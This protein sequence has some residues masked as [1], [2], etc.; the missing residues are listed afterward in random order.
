MQIIVGKVFLS[1]PQFHFFCFTFAWATH[2]VNYV[3]LFA[4]SGPLAIR[5]VTFW[6]SV[7]VPTYWTFFYFCMRHI[8]KKIISINNIHTPPTEHL[9]QLSVHSRTSTEH[10]RQ[11]PI[12]FLFAEDRRSGAS[13]APRTT[14]R[15]NIKNYITKYL[16]NKNKLLFYDPWPDCYI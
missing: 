9:R 12:F 4:S 7:P 16:H 8:W 5:A 1:I 2:D 15:I 10:L 6:D 11:C 14:I 3:G 13:G